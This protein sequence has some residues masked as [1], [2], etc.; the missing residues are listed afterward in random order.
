MFTRRI[1]QAPLRLYPRRRRVGYPLDERLRF[2]RRCSSFKDARGFGNVG[3]PI[4]IVD[5][6]VDAAVGVVEA[7]RRTDRA[8][9]GTAARGALDRAANR[10]VAIHAEVAVD[11]RDALRHWRCHRHCQVQRPKKCGAVG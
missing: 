11:S 9:S 1:K 5:D 8:A 3:A 6:A 10:V 7:V 2:R 4:L